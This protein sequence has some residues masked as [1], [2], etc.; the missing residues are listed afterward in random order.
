ML[1]SSS[2]SSVTVHPDV[3][4]LLLVLPQML[5]SLSYTPYRLCDAS[6][7]AHPGFEKSLGVCAFV[8]RTRVCVCVFCLCNPETGDEETLFALASET[9]RGR[10]PL[11]SGEEGREGQE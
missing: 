10:S 11:V 4:I 1:S 2:S 7:V 6:I 8:S 9:H 3:V 5:P